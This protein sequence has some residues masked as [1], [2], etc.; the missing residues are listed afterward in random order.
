MTHTSVWFITSCTCLLLRFNVQTWLKCKAFL[1]ECCHISKSLAGKT[2]M[3]SAGSSFFWFILLQALFDVAW[4]L[5]YLRWRIRKSMVRA[6]KPA[7]LGSQSWDIYSMGHHDTHPPTRNTMESK[8]PTDRWQLKKRWHFLFSC[9]K[10]RTKYISWRAYTLMNSGLYFV[11]NQIAR[12]KLS[13]W[14]A[15]RS[16]SLKPPATP[17]QFDQAGKLGMTRVASLGHAS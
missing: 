3:D 4:L 16:M 5:L 12:F 17:Y 2:V 15:Q 1:P 14:N 13:I 9:F 8:A 6:S 7:H 11:V 10:E